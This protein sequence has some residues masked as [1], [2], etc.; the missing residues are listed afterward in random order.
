VPACSAFLARW[1]SPLAASEL[2]AEAQACLVLP[3]V[4]ACSRGPASVLAYFPEQPLADDSH[5]PVAAP[6][7]SLAQPLADG[8]RSPVEAPGDSLAR[9]LADDSHSP[10]EALA[11]FQARLPADDS[12]SPA[13][14]C[15][16]AEH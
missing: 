3:P 9:P 12:H 8:S 6:G 10:A 7:D 1:A 2:A 15:P 5:L 4:Q 16:D 13:A 14:D 11:D